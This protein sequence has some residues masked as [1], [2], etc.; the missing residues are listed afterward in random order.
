M[1]F[2]MLPSAWSVWYCESKERV[3][4]VFS[5][6]G[7]AVG[8]KMMPFVRFSTQNLQIQGLEREICMD[9]RTKVQYPC[10]VR[11]LLY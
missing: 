10:A 3:L 5:Y 7:D 2:F 8:L 9:Y 6:K 1:R 11:K 4:Y